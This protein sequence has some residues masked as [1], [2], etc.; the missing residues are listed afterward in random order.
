MKWLNI[1]SDIKKI[2]PRI[3]LEYGAA[4]V[5]LALFFDILVFI[6]NII[7]VIGG[8]IAGWPLE[9]ANWGSMF[10]LFGFK[11]VNFFKNKKMAATGV[12]A[13]IFGIIPILNALPEFTVSAARIVILS[14]RDDLEA[15][16]KTAKI[17]KQ[18]SAQTQQAQAQVRAFQEAQIESQQLVGQE[19]SA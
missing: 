8:V 4:I 7:P 6:F 12:I 18:Q 13:I 14:W 17:M 9:I 15:A 2:K 10:L 3:S 16:E 19:I 5:L 11:G 1:L